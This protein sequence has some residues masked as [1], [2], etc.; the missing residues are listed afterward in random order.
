MRCL[1]LFRLRSGRPLPFVLFWCATFIGLTGYL[2]YLVTLPPRVP[3]WPTDPTRPPELQPN[4]DDATFDAIKPR[5]LDFQ[6]YDLLR[7]E[8]AVID[9]P[10]WTPQT[11]GDVPGFDG[12]HFKAYK[13]TWRIWR[14]SRQPGKWIAVGIVW[15][16]RFSHVPFVAGKRKNGF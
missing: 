5:M 1:T 2:S 3:D 6:V 9:C 11:L 4:I 7:G 12:D 13:V 15:D 16:G 14:S 8:G 10:D